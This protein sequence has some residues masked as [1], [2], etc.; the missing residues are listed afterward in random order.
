MESRLFT[1]QLLSVRQRQ[2]VANAAWE[3]DFDREVLDVNGAI[4]RRSAVQLDVF[5]LD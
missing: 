3:L 2:A 4:S 5:A 1:V